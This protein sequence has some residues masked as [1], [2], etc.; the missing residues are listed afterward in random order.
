MN[1]SNTANLTAAINKDIARLQGEIF[2]L[3][4]KMGRSSTSATQVKHLNTQV[5]VMSERIAARL[6]LLE[7]Q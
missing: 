7:L 4:N 5:V 2:M 1:T 6:Q 3:V